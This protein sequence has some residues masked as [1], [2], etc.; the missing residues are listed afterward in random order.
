MRNT[1]AR[2]AKRAR[3]VAIASAQDGEH[4]Q[5]VT[6]RTLTADWLTP[7]QEVIYSAAIERLNV[8]ISNVVAC[9]VTRCRLDLRM[10]AEKGNAVVMNRQQSM[11]T[12]QL[13]RPSCIACIWARGKVAVKGCLSES[14]ARLAGR[15]IA[16]L[17]QKLYA[18]EKPTTARLPQFADFDVVNVMAVVKFPFGIK[19]QLVNDAYPI[20]AFYEPELH[21]ACTFRLT[22]KPRATLSMFETGSMTMTSNSEANIH[23][24]VDIIYP[25][26]RMYEK[27]A[28][29]TVKRKAKSRRRRT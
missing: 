23:L 2:R 9:F 1:R 6:H 26:L 10:I 29:E 14:D 25:I 11:V 15:R 4:P 28:Q 13:K 24:A 12:M 17:L 18:R 3:M 22:E 19:L 16:R 7:E 5:Q 8:S 20:H 27:D 21:P